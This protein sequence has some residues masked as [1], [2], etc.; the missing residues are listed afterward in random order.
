M[1]KYF[2]ENGFICEYECVLHAYLCII[3][4]IIINNL[5]LNIKFTKFITYEKLFP[6][7]NIDNNIYHYHI[8]NNINQDLI[9]YKKIINCLS[10]EVKCLK[11]IHFFIKL[12]YINYVY[13]K[14]LTLFII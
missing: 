13:I 12:K 9:N 4:Q 7:N 5:M 2:R 3:K 1:I 11:N 6:N 8:D 10:N 14:Y